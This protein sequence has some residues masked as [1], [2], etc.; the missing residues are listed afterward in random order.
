MFPEPPRPTSYETV[1]HDLEIGGLSQHRSHPSFSTN[2]SH[3]L[4]ASATIGGPS[5]EN[6]PMRRNDHPNEADRPHVQEPSAGVLDAL[7]HPTTRLTDAP[8]KLKSEA[9]HTETKT[10]KPKVFRRPP[11]VPVLLPEHRYCSI[12]EIVKPYRAHHCRNCGT[13]CFTRFIS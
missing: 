9:H 4:N 6:I 10:P 12:D 2:Q 13:V 3:D 8:V 5:Y 1:E 7:P 11:M